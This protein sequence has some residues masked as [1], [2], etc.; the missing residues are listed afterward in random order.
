M[1]TE[2]NLQNSEKKMCKVKKWMPKKTFIKFFIFSIVGLFIIRGAYIY[3]SDYISDKNLN[4]AVDEI[5]Q[6]FETGDET[7]KIEYAIRILSAE[8]NWNYSSV[9]DSK[10][11]EQLKNKGY[12][13]K[14]FE[15]IESMAFNGNAKCQ[16]NLAKLYDSS[17]TTMKRSIARSNEEINDYW[18]VQAAE[19][20]YIEAYYSAAYALIRKK[21][22][23]KGHEFIKKGAEAGDADCQSAYGDF[24]LEES[25]SY[26]LS[27]SGS[28]EKIYKKEGLEEAKEWWRKSAKQGN[29]WAKAKLQY[30]YNYY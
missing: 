12:L 4:N 8:P 19:Q 27:P 29:E 17:D 1:E 13:T 16:Y 23:E 21:K 22:K 24:I 30:I 2:N 5:I 20:G 28:R 9:S 15:Y 25:Q 18:S 3:I 14:S 10:I 11:E 7:T 26:S 6:N